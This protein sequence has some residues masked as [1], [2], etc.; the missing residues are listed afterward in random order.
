M[1]QDVR[2]KFRSEG[3]REP[4]IHEVA[5]GWDTLDWI[6]QQAWST[7]SVG[8]VGDSYYGFTQWAAAASGHRALKAI[9]PRVTGT[10]FGRYYSP[11][12]VPRVPFFAWLFETWTSAGLYEG[13][14]IHDP[15]HS[16]R[17]AH[18]TVAR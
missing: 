10:W 1:I 3:E 6:E 13:E 2:G 18:S 11:D 14:L 8:M 15:P 9:V 16:R 12:E 7:G 5:D 4:F 17:P